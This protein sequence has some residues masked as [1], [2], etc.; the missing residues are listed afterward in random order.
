MSSGGKS[1]TTTTTNTPWKESQPY[2]RQGMAEAQ[3]LYNTT[4][5]VYSSLYSGMSDPTLAG[6]E[7][8]AQYGAGRGIVPDA[9]DYAARVLR[10]ELLYSNPWLDQTFNTAAGKARQ[11]FDSQ[12]ARAGRYG[13]DAHSNVAMEGYNQLANQIYGG[14]YQAERDRMQGTLGM[15]GQ[16]EQAG[17]IRPQAMINAGTMIDDDMAQYLFELNRQQNF[18]YENSW[19]RLNRYLQA[20]QGAG[21]LQFGGSQSSQPLYKNRAAGAL[22][23]ALA[24]AQIGSVVPGIGTAIGAIG[25]G[26][27][28]AF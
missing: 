26:L 15:T 4:S 21:G 13:S 11:A 1:Q 12:F 2:L 23:G 18:G 9:Q 22:G 6:I 20:V 28:G 8:M 10:G 14:N 19:D 24:G 25:G 17:L 27:L 16:L 3:R 7:G 5:P